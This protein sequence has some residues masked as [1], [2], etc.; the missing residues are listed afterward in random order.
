MNLID[1]RPSG[2]ENTSDGALWSFAADQPYVLYA[3]QRTIF[4]LIKYEEFLLEVKKFKDDIFTEGDMNRSRP[5]VDLSTLLTQR[6][7]EALLQPVIS[8]VLAQFPVSQGSVSFLPGG[9]GP[10]LSLPEEP[11]AA[12]F[13]RNWLASFTKDFKQSQVAANIDERILDLIRIRKWVENYQPSESLEPRVKKNV[14]E[15]LENL[16]KEYQNICNCNQIGQKLS[17]LTQWES[18]DLTVILFAYLFQNYQGRPINT[19]EDLLYKE[20]SQLELWKLIKEAA[21]TQ[22]SISK[23]DK[24][25]T[26]I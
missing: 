7:A 25:A 6:L 11:W 9:T 13:V 21:G 20:S 15:R 24:T 16:K 22:D 23:I 18:A 12:D 5:E 26:F 3:T 10:N 19:F 14:I 8:Q 2:S 1:R 4:A 17:Q